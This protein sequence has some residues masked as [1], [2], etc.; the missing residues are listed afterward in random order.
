MGEEDGGSVNAGIWLALLYVAFNVGFHVGQMH[1]ER[2]V[3]RELGL[4]VPPWKQ[5]IREHFEE[6]DTEP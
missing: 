2:G 1:L 6:E 4:P 5:T 3:L